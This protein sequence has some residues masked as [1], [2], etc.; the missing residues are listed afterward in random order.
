MTPYPKIFVPLDNWLSGLFGLSGM[1]GRC[2]GQDGV[3][4]LNFSDEQQLA[5]AICY[6]SVYGEYCTEYV[7]AGA[8]ALTVITNDAW[9]G[10]TPGYRQHLSYSCLRAIELR[11]D[12]ARCGN[13]GISAFINQKGDIVQSSPWWEEAS[14]KG[15]IKLNSEKT[16]FAENGDIVGRIC[17]FLFILM[18]AMLL[19]RAIVPKR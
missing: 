10:N 9:W 12:I 16:F 17:T 2:V 4:V 1:M 13:T 18:A 11:R 6:E 3:S 15:E 14:L 5:C 19:V 7:N 8:K